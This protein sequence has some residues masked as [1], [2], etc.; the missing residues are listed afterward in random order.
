MS[1]HSIFFPKLLL[2]TNFRYTYGISSLSSFLAEAVMQDLEK[3]SVTN[4]ND[5]K[6]WNRYVDDVLA[7]V[8]KDKTDDILHT[9]NNTIENIKFTKEEE[10]NSQLAFLDVL[11]TRTDDGTINTQIYRKKTYIDQILNFNSNHPTQHKISC[12]RSLFNQIDTHCNTEQ[13]KRT[14]R[15]YLYSTFMKNNYPRNFI[16]K[17]LTKIRNKPQNNIPNEQPKQSR[18]RITL[19][20]INNTSE[21]TARLLRPFN[22]DIAHKHINSGH[23]SQNTKTKQRQ[24]KRKMRYT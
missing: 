1:L 17:T 12:I 10:E 6:T 19:P 5:I 8:K 16:N 15:K 24:N 14:E 21:M 23:I 9:I 4:N 2:Q 13:T 7:A 3:R 22:I 20:Y 11:L 18:T